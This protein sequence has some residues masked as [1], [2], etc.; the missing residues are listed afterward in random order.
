MVCVADSC[1]NDGTA[2]WWATLPTARRMPTSSRSS[3]L[4][5]KQANDATQWRICVA[6][7]SHSSRAQIGGDSRIGPKYLKP[8]FGFG[9]PCFPRDNRAFGQYAE[10]LGIEPMLP[11]ATDNYNAV[12]ATYMADLLLKQNLDQVPHLILLILFLS[13]VQ[14]VPYSYSREREQYTFEDV[15]YKEKS[16]VPIIEE[17]QKLVVRAELV[18]VV[19][20][21]GEVY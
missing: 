4:Y 2:T 1:R 19:A 15:A 13:S 10:S 3:K 14:S 17:S 6:H 9:G 7:I 20:V 8:G 21:V 12:H 5:V 16:S 18:A 11:R